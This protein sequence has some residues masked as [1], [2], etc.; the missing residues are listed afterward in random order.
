MRAFDGETLFQRFRFTQSKEATRARCV[1][2]NC[3]RQALFQYARR[4][5][6]QAPIKSS[7]SALLPPKGVNYWLWKLG[8]L[9][10]I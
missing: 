10:C 9:D 4:L 5:V 7:K 1:F 8:D 6:P 2:G 3:C